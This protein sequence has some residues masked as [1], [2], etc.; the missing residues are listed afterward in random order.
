MHPLQREVVNVRA[1]LEAGLVDAVNSSPIDLNTAS[2]HRLQ[3]VSGL[4]ATLAREI[5]SYRAQNKFTSRQQLLAVPHLTTQVYEQCA[6][7]VRIAI[8][9]ATNTLD[10]TRV[11]LTYCRT[12]QIT[13]E[14]I[15]NHFIRRSTPQITRWLKIFCIRLT[16]QLTV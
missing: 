1:L 8:D 12:H 13:F 9:V 3:H 2:F 4:T 11:N 14:L 6:G 15:V 16:S 5:M 10:S 7:F